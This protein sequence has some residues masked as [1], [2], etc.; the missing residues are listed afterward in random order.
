MT[1]LKRIG[2]A[3]LCLAVL[4]PAAGAC[5]DS[6]NGTAAALETVEVTSPAGGTLESLNLESG[7][8]VTEGAGAGS[9][10]MDKVFAPFDGT[11]AAVHAEEGEKT[12]GTVLEISPTSL[13]T[14]TC[15]VK[16]TVQTPENALIH[17]GE[18][19]YVRCTADG[20]H[21]AVAVVTA[22]SGSDYT[23]E[24]TAGELYVGETVYLYRDEACTPALRV[25]KGTVT[26]HDPLT[27][28]A[29]GVIRNLRVQQGDKVKRGQWIFSVSS[30]EENRITVPASGTVT[31]VKAAVGDSVAE[32]QALAEIAVSCVLKI[33]VSADDAGLFA[34]GQEWF[35][36]R[37]DDDHEKLRPCRVRRVL[38]NSGDAS[39]E[40][41]LIPE[42]GALLPI[43]LTVRITD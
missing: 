22:I 19:L 1:I 31:E 42:D 26:S 21:R 6:W 20:S 2:T 30:S 4:L 32:D 27:V 7:T 39:A 41:E 33:S 29:D 10:R 28:S 15:T 18:T 43:G 17:I 37:G 13:Y 14:L 3:L 16:N 40:V 9:V 36:I 24:T 38:L 5:A 11:V 34:A 23:A 35:Y 12:N 8:A 25:G